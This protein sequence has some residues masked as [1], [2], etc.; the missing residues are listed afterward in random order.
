MVGVPPNSVLELCP[1]L[2]TF[3]PLRDHAGLGLNT[4]F[5]NYPIYVLSS[6]LSLEL[7]T[8]HPSAYQHYN[9]GNY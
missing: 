3:T 5:D 6:E 4:Y 1:F 8:L 2:S 7:K 9:L